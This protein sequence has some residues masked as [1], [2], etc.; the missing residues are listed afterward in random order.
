L[1]IFLYLSLH[2]SKSVDYNKLKVYLLEKD[3]QNIIANFDGRKHNIQFNNDYTEFVST[4]IGDL[5]IDYGK[6]TKYMF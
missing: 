1:K 4:R 6:L 2:N 3:K 5:Q